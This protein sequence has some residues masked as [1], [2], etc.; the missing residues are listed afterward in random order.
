[1][2]D[3]RLCYAIGGGEH[4]SE[5]TRIVRMNSEDRNFGV[6]RLHG[7]SS[8]EKYSQC[9]RGRNGLITRTDPYS[10]PCDR[11]SEYRTSAPATCAA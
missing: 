9:Q 8:D 11:S 7:P 5:G 3:L 1:M 6:L 2:R 10:C 4:A